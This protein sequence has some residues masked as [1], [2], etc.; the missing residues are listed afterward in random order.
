MNMPIVKFKLAVLFLL[1]H[2][3]SGFFRRKIL[4]CIPYA[5]FPISYKVGTTT[6]FKR[7]EAQKTLYLHILSIYISKRCMCF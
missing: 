4:F 3:L 5:F 6:H 7:K 1:S 2:T